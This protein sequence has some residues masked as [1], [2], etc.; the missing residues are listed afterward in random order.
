MIYVELSAIACPVPVVLAPRT[1]VRSCRFHRHIGLRLHNNAHQ[2]SAVRI[3]AG[4]SEHT[5]TEE[6]AIP[7]ERKEAMSVVMLLSL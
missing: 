6:K 7:K 3:N 2:I 4:Q 1:P 5:S